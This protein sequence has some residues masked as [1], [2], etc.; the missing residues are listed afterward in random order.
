[1][2][3]SRHCEEARAQSHRLDDEASAGMQR[4]WTD[5]S[6]QWAAWAASQSRPDGPQGRTHK[7]YESRPS[8]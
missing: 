7:K 2:H 4:R 8:A 1:M 6:T 3:K 5:G